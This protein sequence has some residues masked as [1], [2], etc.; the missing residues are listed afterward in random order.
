MRQYYA[1]DFEV[2]ITGLTMEADVKNA[3]TSISYTNDLDKVDQVEITLDNSDFRFLD[4]ALFDVGKEVE[5]HMGYAGNLKPM[6]LGDITA[7]QPSF[8]ESGAPTFEFRRHGG[9]LYR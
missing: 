3:V 2:K 7:V 1:P 4:S 5:V 9:D 6:L 8:P